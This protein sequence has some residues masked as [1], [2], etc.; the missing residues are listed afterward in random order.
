[1]SDSDSKI[2]RDL[3]DW[4]TELTTNTTAEGKYN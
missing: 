4:L 2:T 3:T 1:M